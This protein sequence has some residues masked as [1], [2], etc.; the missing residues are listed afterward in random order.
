MLIIM[1]I[2]IKLELL[3]NV[4]AQIGMIFW[5]VVKTIRVFHFK[6]S[7]IEN[8]QGWNGIDPIF[9][10]NAIVIIRNWFE[11]ILNL[12]MFSTNILIELFD[13]IMSLTRNR[14]DEINL[15]KKYVN[16]NSNLLFVFIWSMDEHRNK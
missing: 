12:F 16:K 5:I 9:S 11:L 6:F 13:C 15:T 14:A 3:K 8:T 4:N 1:M 2:I 7:I 10:K